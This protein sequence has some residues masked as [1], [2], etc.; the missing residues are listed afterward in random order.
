MKA[1]TN[2]WH[3]E[4][5]AACG[6]YDP[7]PR[8]GAFRGVF[9]CPRRRNPLGGPPPL[10]SLAGASGGTESGPL[11][12]RKTFTAGAAC[13][14][15][16]G[17]GLRV[18]A[19][20]P[21]ASPKIRCRAAWYCAARSARVRCVSADDG[22]AEAEA[23]GAEG[24]FRMRMDGCRACAGGA[25]AAA[26]TSSGIGAR[27]FLRRGGQR[28]CQ[29]LRTVRGGAREGSDSRIL[30]EL[31]WVLLLLLPRG[32]VVVP[33][34]RHGARRADGGGRVVCLRAAQ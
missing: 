2:G 11:G 21:S 16:C 24:R 4:A 13:V 8:A 23:A 25:V 1:E 19:P 12:L 9:C 17:G 31:V 33:V 30:P 26:M 22:A 20:P 28:A 34:V 5:Q 18:A 14:I 29:G 3:R 7:R 27:L 32:R 10:A 15:V 6:Y